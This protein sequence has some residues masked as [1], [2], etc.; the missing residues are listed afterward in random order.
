MNGRESL[1]NK[2]FFRKTLDI[3]QEL[4]ILINA[5]KTKEV[6]CDEQR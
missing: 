2:G 4:D 1:K 6:M 3:R 5:T